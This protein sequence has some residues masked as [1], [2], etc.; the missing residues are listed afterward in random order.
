MLL[1]LVVFFLQND[2]L[3]SVGRG[4]RIRIMLLLLYYHISI[5]FYVADEVN[6][7]C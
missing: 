5:P 2:S 4:I 3:K 1:T 7:H 6:S